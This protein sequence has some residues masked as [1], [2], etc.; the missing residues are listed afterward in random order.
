MKMLDKAGKAR[1]KREREKPSLQPTKTHPGTTHA[2]LSLPITHTKCIDPTGGNG[3]F[4]H[5]SQNWADDF[6]T[7]QLARSYA[8]VPTCSESATNR[9]W[10]VL[11]MIH[12]IGEQDP[13]RRRGVCVSTH[14][15]LHE[16]GCGGK[17]KT[18]NNVRD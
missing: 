18:N 14:T 13:R 17:G 6:S 7:I 16:R 15:P 10:G 3:R 2:F 4:A 1:V 11:S 9:A 12:G 8:Q 5:R